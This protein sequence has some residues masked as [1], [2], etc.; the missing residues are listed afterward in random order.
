MKTTKNIRNRMITLGMAAVIAVSAISITQTVSAE[1]GIE[2]QEEAVTA[3]EGNEVSTESVEGLEVPMAANSDAAIEDIQDIDAD[4]VIMMDAKLRRNAA[5]ADSITDEEAGTE[6]NAGTAAKQPKKTCKI[7]GVKYVLN[8]DGKSYYVKEYHL[9]NLEH[10]VLESEIDGLLVTSIGDKAFHALKGLKSIVIPEGIASIGKE[11]FSHCESLVDITIPD[12]VKNIGSDAFW[13]CTSL[14]DII[15]PDG[16]TCLEKSLFYG[17]RNL[18]N[19]TIP[20]SVTDM[21][22]G[23][24]LGCAGLKNI[25]LP[26]NLKTIGNNAFDTCISLES[27]V[28][29]E[30]VTS[31]GRCAFLDCTN[32]KNV[33]LPSGLKTLELSVFNGCASLEKIS[34]PEGITSI[35]E[36]AFEDCVS[37][38]DISIPS[39]VDNIGGYAFSG[40][41]SLT[42][43]TIPA[44]VKTVDASAFPVTMHTVLF[45][46]N[47][48]KKLDVSSIMVNNGKKIGS[49]PSA[50]RSG[51]VLKG[52]YTAKSGGT[53]VTAK[54]VVKEDLKLYARWEKVKKPGKVSIK[55]LSSKKNRRMTITCAKVKN[56]DGYQVVYSTTKKFTKKTTQKVT[57]A[58]K[59]CTLK[60]LTSGKEYFVK[61]RAYRVDS[62]GKKHYGKFS[63]VRRVTVK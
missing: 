5:S 13:N 57:T 8:D 42:N 24:F 44:S 59:N 12:S 3:M 11:A 14:T 30:G 54:T 33:V 40:C 45:S 9:T 18:K 38:T 37:L 43:V 34:L 28:I 53:K 15:I 20:E 26:A 46:A 41:T 61:V 23:V 22:Y 63:A 62:A 55:N 48:G 36:G 60:K 17:C 1:D 7:N 47:G 25:L 6:E 10:V 16:V 29:P 2:A 39:G 4:D 56:A 51:Y 58:K 35:E 31:I 27:I 49:L 50:K 19:V 52:W 21:Q 32:L